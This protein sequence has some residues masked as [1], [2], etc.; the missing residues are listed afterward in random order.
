M[1]LLEPEFYANGQHDP[2]DISGNVRQWVPDWL[3]D[4]YNIIFPG[5]NPYIIYPTCFYGL[6]PFNHGCV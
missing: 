1:E 5:K 6:S 2:L 3:D 4:R